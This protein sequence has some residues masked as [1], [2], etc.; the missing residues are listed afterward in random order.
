MRADPRQAVFR[1]CNGLATSKNWPHSLPPPTVNLQPMPYNGN[2]PIVCTSLLHAIVPEW[3]LSLHW[4]LPFEAQTVWKVAQDKILTAPDFMA[5]SG[6]QLKSGFGKVVNYCRTN[7]CSPPA[8][9][10]YT[11]QRLYVFTACFSNRY[12]WWSVMSRLRLST[13][14]NSSS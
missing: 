10:R 1:E 12:L 3:D 7:H 2:A 13:A 14:D 6:Q 9:L 8:Y 5:S 11:F 4:T